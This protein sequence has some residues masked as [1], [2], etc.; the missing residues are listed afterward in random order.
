[1]TDF[2]RLLRA[3]TDASVRYILGAAAQRIVR[4]VVG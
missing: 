4:P 2:A 3:L 1:M